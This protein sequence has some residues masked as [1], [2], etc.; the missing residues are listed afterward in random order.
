[1]VY[2]NNMSNK[3]RSRK[4]KYFNAMVKLARLLISIDVD[5]RMKMQELRETKYPKL[6]NGGTVYGTS[7]VLISGR[8]M[9]LPTISKGATPYDNDQYMFQND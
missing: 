1:M 9:V 5:F 4:R 6:A 8:E 3:S 7:S 2:L